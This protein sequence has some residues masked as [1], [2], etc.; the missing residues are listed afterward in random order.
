MKNATI[1]K[2]LSSLKRMFNLGLKAKP[3]KVINIPNI[4]HLKE[5][6]ART[7]FFEYQA[8]KGTLPNRLKSVVAVAYYTGMRKGRNLKP[9]VE[10]GGFN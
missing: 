8:L 5:N 3:R 7:G 9:K 4:P 2:E 6:N 10:P 1:N